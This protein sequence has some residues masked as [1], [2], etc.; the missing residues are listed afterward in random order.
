MTHLA[1]KDFAEKAKLKIKKKENKILWEQ[2]F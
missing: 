1:K 2:N